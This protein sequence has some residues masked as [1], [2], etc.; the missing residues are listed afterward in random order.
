MCITKLLFRWFFF[1][2]SLSLF[3]FFLFLFLSLSLFLFLFLSSFFPLFLWLFVS[4]SSKLIP[5]W[6]ERING[7]IVKWHMK[8]TTATAFPHVELMPIVRVKHFVPFMENASPLLFSLPLS[9]SLSR[10]RKSVAS[11]ECTFIFDFTLSAALSPQITRRETSH[12]VR[13]PASVSLPTLLSLLLPYHVRMALWSFS[14]P[15]LAS[16]T[17]FMVIASLFLSHSHS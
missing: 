12:K 10:L 3:L 15:H 14:F 9:L 2:L 11:L 4:L 16:L 13:C 17:L 6:K 1:S 8:M 5:K 7:D